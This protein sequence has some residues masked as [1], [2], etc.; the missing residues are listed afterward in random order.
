A[1]TTFA[2]MGRANT[3]L[4]LRQGPSPNNEA[5]GLVTKNSRVRI[6]KTQNNWYQVDILEQGRPLAEP[7]ESNRG[8][9]NGKY[10]DPE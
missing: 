5:V 8:W 10:I 6:V 3:D 1:G 9:L 2:K 7:N 4:N